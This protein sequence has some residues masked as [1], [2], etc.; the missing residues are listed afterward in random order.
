MIDLFEHATPT[1]PGLAYR[2]SFISPPEQTALL[3]QIDA[4]P[5]RQ[6]LKRRV[7]HYGYR[8]DYRARS[9]RE[10]EG[11][12]PLPGWLAGVCG[13]LVEEGVFRERPEQVIVNEYRPGEGISAHRDCVPCF[14]ETIASLSLGAAVTMVFSQPAS[15][16]REELRLIPGSLLVLSGPARHDWRHGIPARKSDSVGCVRIARGRRVSLTFRTMN[17]D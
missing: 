10:S 3:A 5:W 6:D 8:Y 11:L 1:I 12:G 4:A 16:A 15:G 17:W 13:R 9:A 7:Q 2:E 14:G